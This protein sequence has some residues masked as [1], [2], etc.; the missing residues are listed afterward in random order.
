MNASFHLRLIHFN[1]LH[2]RLAD[3][4]PDGV[5]P[6]FSRM[7]GF[8]REAREEAAGRPD[9]G[10]LVL[11]GGDEL[12]GSPFAELAG[13]RPAQFRC[14]PAYA[15]Y[16]A[17]GV[18]ACVVG[19]HDLDWGLDMLARAADQDAR[20]PLLSANLQPGPGASFVD[21]HPAT[22][23]RVNGLRV[24]VI[25]LTTPGEIKHVVPG[26]F[27]IGDPL[28]A[29][30]AAVAALQACCDVLVLLSHLGHSAADGDGVMGGA[31]LDAGDA[32]VARAL[33]AGAVSV[34]V[35][36]HT[37]TILNR[38]G[39]DPANLVNGALLVQAGSFG[40]YIGD[41]LIQ[42]TG[43]GGRARTGSGQALSARLWP[44]EDLPVD[45][46]FD[47]KY[48]RPIIEMIQGRLAEP[49]GVVSPHQDLDPGQMRQQLA[50]EESALANFVADALAV[51]SRA[52]GYPVDF[53]LVDASAVCDGLPSEGPITFAD[54]FR[55][56]PYADSIV[57][58]TL[59]S[60]DLQ[61][62]LDDNARRVDL[63]GEAHD[64]RG[65]LHFSREV[66]YRIA[67]E[68]PIGE[69]ETPGAGEP[70]AEGEG[71][72]RLD[73][74]RRGDVTVR[75]NSLCAVD[76]SLAGAA[77]AQVAQ[78]ST[79]VLVAGSSFVRQ[80][81]LNWERR[82]RQVGWTVFDL[83]ALPQQATPLAVREA[84]VAYVWQ[85]GGVTEAGGL[86]RDGRV[87]F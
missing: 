39:L 3:F 7:A 30:V 52:A 45:R 33:P 22:I 80:F 58:F 5:R 67:E 15:V 76:I 85:M 51:A 17:A 77:I 74:R 70:P 73:D 6:V 75:R 19:N 66:R 64:E 86:R 9:M 63:P 59:P 48:V 71:R 60:A 23:L 25:G 18:D 2:G 35:G 40:Q 24:G 47:S 20:F 65:F 84:L 53:A 50:A 4:H 83:A 43:P 42:V 26:E 36:S 21:L 10:V 72:R 79:P 1:D 44:V 38:D 8:I 62:L 82:A 41:V 28:A 54:V 87:R 46:E 29:G 68:A 31:G 57:L 32:E 61:A 14:H 12:V 49:L 13:V 78:R 27:E 69:Q 16:S 55:L 34:I 11:A 56:S 37:H 81:A